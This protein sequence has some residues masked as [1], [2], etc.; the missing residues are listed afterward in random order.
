[1]SDSYVP[2]VN[3]R[4]TLQWI[5]ACSAI[6]SSSGF[7]VA[8]SADVVFT[9]NQSGYG[10]DPNLKNPVIP[11]SRSMT[12]QQL[13]KTALLTDLI[14]PASSSLGIPEFVDE[15]VSA[16]YPQQQKDGQTFFAGLDWLDAEARRRADQIFSELSS[17]VRA[18]I[19]DDLAKGVVAGAAATPPAFFERARFLVI[20]AY[21][22][23]P[24]GFQD[25]GYIGNVPMP[26]YPPITNE[27]RQQLDTALAGLGL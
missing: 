24:K 25:I 8:E 15:W 9:A 10:T 7:R 14:L 4:T 5:A 6:M 3:R 19:I 21:Y 2:R 16:P 22:T 18:S 20:I 13:Q 26:S 12:Q 11:W 1:V 23:T 17:D 27:E